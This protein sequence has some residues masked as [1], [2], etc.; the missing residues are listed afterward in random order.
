MQTF[1]PLSPDINE[2]YSYII[3][4]PNLLKTL[5]IVGAISW[6]FVLWWFINF[7]GHNVWY[8]VFLA[9][10][11]AYLTIYQYISIFINLFYRKFD[12]ERHMKQRHEYWASVQYKPTIDVFLPV[13]GEDLS[14]LRN[15]WE[16]VK[17]MTNYAYTIDPIVLDDAANYEVEEL[18]REYWFR[19]MSRPNR[20]EMKKA[21]NLKYW[22]ERTHGEYIVILD[23]DFKPRYDFLEELLPYMSDEWTGIV[24]SPQFFD[25]DA[26]MHRHSWLEYWA[27]NIQHYFYSI[28]QQSRNSFGGSICVGSCAIYR[29]SALQSVWGTAQVEHSEDVHTWFR[30]IDAGWKIQ[31]VPLP[32]SKGVCP[33]DLL[34]FFKQQTRWCSGSM[35]MMTNARFWNS[36]ISFMTKLCYIS[37][38]MYYI[39]NPLKLLLIVQSIFLFAYHA[40]SIGFANL[41]IFVPTI[42]TSAFIQLIYIYPRAK[43]GTFLT[44]A[45]VTWFYTYTL[46]NLLIWHIEGW[47]PTGLRQNISSRFIGLYICAG[48]YLFLSIGIVFVMTLMGQIDYGNVYFFP[49]LFW[50]FL[51]IAYHSVFV[52]YWVIYLYQK[53]SYAWHKSHLMFRRIMP[54]LLM[55]VPYMIL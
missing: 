31:Y 27:G 11:I 44:H 33:S 36:R 54:A 45:C 48:L 13:C 4:H 10:I 19:Y 34:A 26:S 16:G 29:R 53:K 24:Q 39:S 23:A 32:L 1:L 8:W 37:G 55:F 6:L 17:K 18:A 9:P 30:V 52:G 50:D 25:F 28:I 40:E 15:T 7:F 43:L 21:G 12:L 5:Y 14:I 2:K 38:F 49:S 51:A 47:T 46:V 42:I 20:G 41:L 35:S 22:F 3:E